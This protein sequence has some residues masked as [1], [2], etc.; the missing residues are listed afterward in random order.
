M[1]NLNFISY[2]STIFDLTFIFW[3]FQRP[4]LSQHISFIPYVYKIIWKW[5]SYTGQD[6]TKPTTYIIIII[7]ILSLL[8]FSVTQRSRHFL[9]LQQIDQTQEQQW[10]SLTESSISFTSHL[11]WLPACHPQSPM[12]VLKCVCTISTL[13]DMWWILKRTYRLC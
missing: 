4:A 5:M 11:P 13:F 8:L 2:S 1:F 10:M 3:T 6:S 7:I 9:L 12:P